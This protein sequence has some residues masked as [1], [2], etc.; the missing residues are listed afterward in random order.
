MLVWCG[1]LFALGIVAFMDTLF[2]YGEIFRRINSV[3][4]MLVSLGLLVRTS[5]KIRMRT[6]ENLVERVRQLEAILGNQAPP[7]PMESNK[8]QEKQP[9]F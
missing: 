2:N 5:M 6:L 8:K 3:I 9:V 7:R 1:I 4:F